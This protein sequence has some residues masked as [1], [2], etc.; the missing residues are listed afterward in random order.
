AKKLLK[1]LALFPPG[2]TTARSIARINQAM[3]K[4][5]INIETRREVEEGGYA[6]VG[7]PATVRDRL[8]EIVKYLGIGNLLGLFQIGTLP[9]D[10]TEKNL[11]MFAGDV[12]PDLRQEL[13]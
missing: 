6:I 2:Y 5:L 9:A 1:G 11:R 4:F 8:I 10:L 12:L 3:D 13:P 7:S